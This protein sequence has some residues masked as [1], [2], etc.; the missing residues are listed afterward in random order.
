MRGLRFQNLNQGAGLSQARVQAITQSKDGFIWIGTEEGLNR[1]DGY[2]FRV[3]KHDSLDESTISNSWINDLLVDRKGRLWVTTFRG[4][5]L[6]HPETESFIR[7]VEDGNVQSHL[8]TRLRRI[9]ESSEGLLWLGTDKGLTNFD[10][11]TGKTNNYG[12]KDGLSHINIS[13]LVEDR[14]GMIWAGTNSGGLNR[15][16]LQTKRFVNYRPTLDGG[17]GLSSNEIASLLIDKR[18]TLWVG[19]SG[20]G[21]FRYVSSTDRFEKISIPYS[22]INDIKSDADN[23]LWCSTSSGLVSFPADQPDNLTMYHSN[24][25]DSITNEELLTVYEDKAGV[26][27]VGTDSAGLDRA[28]RYAPDFGHSMVNSGAKKGMPNPI[29]AFLEIEE[30]D[31]W[32]GS[33]SGIIQLNRITQDQTLYQHD[34][35]RNPKKG[36]NVVRALYQDVVEPHIIWVGCIGGLYQFNT[37]NKSFIEWEG[38]DQETQ[39]IKFERISN[40]YQDPMDMNIVWIGHFGQGLSWYNRELLEFKHTSYNKTSEQSLSDDSVMF[41][42]RDRMKNLWVG[43]SNGLNRSQSNAQ[44]FQRYYRQPGNPRSLSHNFVKCMY[45]GSGDFEDILWIGTLGG[46]LNRFN[47]KTG[48]F[49]H[50]RERD[51]LPNDYIYGILPDDTGTTLD[52]YQYGTFPF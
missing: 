26:L 4:L 27:W 8:N 51:G 39:I 36:N 40:I 22:M 5:N 17:R 48:L 35:N 16:D 32:L 20:Q 21:L 37:L 3:F 14:D 38:N 7:Y 49:T 52:E 1:Y 44:S 2:H 12:T 11:D 30:S 46:G 50:W 25:Q 45:E 29:F 9:I 47:R 24:Q 18:G 13:S 6:Y 19:T 42:H 23:R 34:P 43:T 10:P 28:D 31:I 41:I 33:Q 15:F